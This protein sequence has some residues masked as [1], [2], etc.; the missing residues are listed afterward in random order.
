MSLWLAIP[1]IFLAAWTGFFAAC[2]CAAAKD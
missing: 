2:L 1:L